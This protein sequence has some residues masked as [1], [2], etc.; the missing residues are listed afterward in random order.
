M[1]TIVFLHAFAA[2]HRSWQPQVDALGDRYR[3]VAP[4]LPGHGDTP[5]PFTL[6]RAV[7]DTVELLDAGPA[8]GTHVVGISGGATVAMLAASTCPVRVAS[9]VLSAPVAHA[10]RLLAVQRLASALMPEGVT[11]AVLR[12]LF[13]GGRDEYAAMAVEDFRRCGKQ[14]YLDT[15]RE[16]A[17]LDARDRL[18]TV[19]APTLVLVGGKDRANASPSA[20]VARHIPEAELRVVPGAGHLWNLEQP[21]LFTRTIEEFVT[22]HHLPR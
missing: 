3:L 18:S 10:P 19:A 16:I 7:D 1:E 12:Q 4:D 21:E 11:A 13:S 9:L 6:R 15:L 14:T 22:A 2:S 20:E 8:G 5:G 17:R